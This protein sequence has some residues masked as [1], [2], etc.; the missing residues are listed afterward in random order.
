[1]VLLKP[2]LDVWE[3]GE[4]NG[5]F[6]GHNPA[7]ITAAAALEHYWSD[8]ALSRRTVRVGRML[9]ERL[10]EWAARFGA[11]ARGRGLIQG[12]ELPEGAVA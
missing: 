1:L 12:L 9:R 4:H 2:E 5:T 6:R 7:F 8:A 10:T 3:P 11:E